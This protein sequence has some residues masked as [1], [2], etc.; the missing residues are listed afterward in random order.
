LKKDNALQ[1]F[2][3][4]GKQVRMFMVNDEPQWVLKDVCDVLDVGN[5]R[6]VAARLDDDEKGVD[7]IDTLGG[8]QETTI[9][10]EPG[11]YNVILLSRKPE[12]KEFKRLVTHEILPSIRR[13]GGYRAPANAAKDETALKRAEAMLNNSRVRV[14]KCIRET[15]RDFADSLSPQSRQA[16]AAYIS[17]TVTGQPGLI[18]LPVV[19]K[20]YT[21]SEIGSAYGVSANM[22]GRLAN[23]HGLKTP[24]FG[25]EVLDKA[26][27]H[28]KQVPSFRYN[29]NGREKLAHIILDE[30]QR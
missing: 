15:I 12:A 8:K 28:D 21:A 1:V 26:R 9:V 19:E 25:F 17:D 29:E 2:E 10:N 7:I 3:F 20:S 27:G 24:E 5:S 11:L 30:C 18:P 4:K 16:I 22:V 13:T 6:D 23:K 14:A